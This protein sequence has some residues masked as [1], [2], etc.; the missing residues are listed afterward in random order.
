M[1]ADSPNSNRSRTLLSLAAIG[2]VYYAVHHSGFVFLDPQ[3]RIATIWPASGLALGLLLLQP[4]RLW[5]HTFAVI[6]VANVISNLL[7]GS[8]VSVSLGFVIASLLELL[9]STW[10]MTRIS[11]DTITFDRVKDVLGSDE[12]RPGFRKTNHARRCRND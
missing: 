9:L 6:A 3:Q 12:T 10:I 7:N 11:R 1:V 2:I 4:R 8:A 5:P